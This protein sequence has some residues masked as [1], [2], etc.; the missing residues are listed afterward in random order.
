MNQYHKGPRPETLAQVATDGITYEI[1][2]R[3]DTPSGVTGLLVKL[4]LSAART[5]IPTQLR[6][7]FKQY[8][9]APVCALQL[10]CYDPHDVEHHLEDSLL[11]Q[12]LLNRQPLQL[13]L[14]PTEPVMVYRLL[15]DPRE[16]GSRMLLSAQAKADS[17]LVEFY[18]GHMIRHFTKRFVLQNAFNTAAQ[19]I[20][21]GTA[22]LV[23]NEATPGAWQRAKEQFLRDFPL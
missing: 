23:P 9:E 20:L 3:E 12:S 4:E 16:E 5:S 13:E 11:T 6:L 22:L 8:D 21:E 7:F 10:D 1:V 15:F 18:D 19:Q 14:A 17:Y 2:V